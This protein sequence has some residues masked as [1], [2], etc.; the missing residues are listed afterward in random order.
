VKMFPLS[1]HEKLFSR[2]NYR[3]SLNLK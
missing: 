2:L 3:L 1:A